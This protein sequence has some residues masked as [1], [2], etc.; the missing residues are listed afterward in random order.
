MPVVTALLVQLCTPRLRLVLLMVSALTTPF[1]CAGAT[2]SDPAR[3]EFAKK[4][5]GLFHA[6]YF[7]HPWE[8]TEHT[9]AGEDW[10]LPP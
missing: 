5:A 8:E 9:V 1:P 7:F 6:K 4:A 2:K 3:D 10:S